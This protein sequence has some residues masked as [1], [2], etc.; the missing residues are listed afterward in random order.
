MRLRV[1]IDNYRPFVSAVD[2]L[3]AGG[4]AVFRENVR[5]DGPPEATYVSEDRD[6]VPADVPRAI[7]ESIGVA[8]PARWRHLDVADQGQFLVLDVKVAGHPVV[9]AVRATVDLPN[10]RRATVCGDQSGC[11]RA[12]AL[13]PAFGRAARPF[14]ADDR[15]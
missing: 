6:G 14:G 12:A 5:V 1:R 10:S 8:G 15:P 9:A 11:G 7:V 3:I 13:T 4:G 2:L